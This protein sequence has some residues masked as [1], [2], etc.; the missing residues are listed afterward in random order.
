MSTNDEME[1]DE[2]QTELELEP[3]HAPL[4]DDA[5]DILGTLAH[6]L[7]AICADP[8]Q[9]NLRAR[10]VFELS[11]RMWWA[12]PE[13]TMDEWQRSFHRG[14]DEVFVKFADDLKERA[15]REE[16]FKKQLE[17]ECKRREAVEWRDLLANL[18]K[19]R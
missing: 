12:L 16:D 7:G 1:D 18:W 14:R 5:C 11:M 13:H 10:D 3:E 9:Y 19:R 4:S 17:R 2:M 6:R 15:S 8:T